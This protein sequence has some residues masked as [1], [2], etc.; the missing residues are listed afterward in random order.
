MLVF[1]SSL[2]FFLLYFKIFYAEIQEKK[3]NTVKNEKFVEISNKNIPNKL[4]VL[5]PIINQ[6]TNPKKDNKNSVVLKEFCNFSSYCER[7]INVE[8]SS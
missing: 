8:S 4:F 2:K 5:K 6:K 3:E 7:E 1:K